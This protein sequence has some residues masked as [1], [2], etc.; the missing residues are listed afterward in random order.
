VFSNAAKGTSPDTGKRET[1]MASNFYAQ[2][3]HN[4]RLVT[5]ALYVYAENGEIAAILLH[6]LLFFATI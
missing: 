2:N 4:R 5:Y 3:T 1:D 6:F